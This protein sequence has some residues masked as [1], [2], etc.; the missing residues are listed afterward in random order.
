MEQRFKFVAAYLK[1]E[2]SMADLCRSFGVSRKTG[3]K[4]LHRYYGEGPG[5]LEDRSSRPRSSPQQTPEVV[6]KA[7]LDL[8]KTYPR[9]GPKKLR[10]VLL[11]HR[12][13][14]EIPAASTIGEVLKRHG[15]VVP[16][17][18]RR[19]ELPRTSPFAKYERPNAVWCANFKGD[20]LA[21]STRCYPLT[22]IDGYSRFLITCVG[23]TK[24]R[25]LEVKKA[26]YA[27]FKQFGLPEVIRTDNG[28]PFA[29]RG[30][31]GLSKL[32]A[33]WIRLGITPE[34]IEPGHP[35]QNGRQERFHRTLKLHTAR[36]PQTSLRKQ[37]LAFSRFRAEYNEVRPHEAL[38]QKP[39]AEF[40]ECSS[41]E[42]PSKRLDPEYDFDFE[43]FMT[44]RKGD[45][46]WRGWR[47][48]VNSCLDRELVGVTETDGVFEVYYGPVCLGAFEKPRTKKAEIQLK[49]V[50]KVLPRSPV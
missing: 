49:R 15:L 42:I 16:R 48:H 17:K 23:L 44:N 13:E 11:V 37:Q 46:N 43:C 40:F 38:G 8:R 50:Q 14:L 31:G 39:P 47:I 30:A 10:A 34:R 1:H 3:Y 25:F 26:F 21:G 35:E 27:A 6:E 24:T 45:I 9:W 5:G 29:S 28:P 41:R 20:F 36:P 2:G 7:I 4:W 33:W 22:I 19:S 18:R 32:S 12:P